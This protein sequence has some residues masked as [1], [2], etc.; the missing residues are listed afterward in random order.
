MYYSFIIYLLY[1]W[2]IIIIIIII[3]YRMVINY[4]YCNDNICK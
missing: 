1:N 2:I 4:Y 3:K